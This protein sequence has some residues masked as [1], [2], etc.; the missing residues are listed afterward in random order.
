MWKKCD[1]S[2]EVEDYDG[3]KLK[4]EKGMDVLIPMHS[5][6]FHPDYFPDPQ[7]F[8]PER[9]D[10]SKGG[11]KKFLE[12]GIL[13][14]FGQGPRM[15]LGKIDHSFQGISYCLTRFLSLQV[16]TLQKCK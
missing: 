11:T 14:P 13:M 12:S 6:H 4:I 3:S 16:Q 8:D 7:T 15:C 1:E 10:E 2:I 5:F 9:F